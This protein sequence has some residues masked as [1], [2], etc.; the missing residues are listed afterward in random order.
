M[1]EA[2]ATLLID[3]GASQSELPDG[4]ERF[5]TLDEIPVVADPSSLPPSPL[6]RERL[7][8]VFDP[9]PLD[10]L[11][12]AKYASTAVA[13]PTDLQGRAAMSRTVID[14]INHVRSSPKAAAAEFRA[15][16]A[17]CFDGLN[18]SPPWRLGGA[19]IVTKEGE[20]AV[21][22]L[23]SHLE[24]LPPLGVLEQHAP[25]EDAA[26]I[27][28]NDLADGR[29]PSA[30][31]KR[32]EPYG[33]WSGVAGEATLYGMRQPE[34]IVTMLLLC[35]GDKGRKNRDFILNSDVKFAAF[36]STELSAASTRFSAGGARLHGPIGIVSLLSAFYPKLEG[37]RTIEFQGPVQ[38]RRRP[39]PRE[40][41]EILDTIPS[42][43]ACELVLTSLQKGKKVKL[44]YANKAVRIT[45]T[46]AQGAS[47]V[48]RLKWS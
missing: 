13:P 31:E 3:C 39:M 19:P 21:A 26:A 5:S 29:R 45:I 41:T 8:S 35:D 32:L 24:K 33:S 20:A 36:A 38:A 42:E 17:G 47:K 43:E 34:A 27:L 37:E 30:I 44:E 4:F 15:R 9:F 1:Q 40:M 2:L 14:H 18:F 16:L 7:S 12:E 10:R 6:T 23:L 48:T 22:E 11:D 28:G 25:L 46:D